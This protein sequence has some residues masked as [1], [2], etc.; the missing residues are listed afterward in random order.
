ML[1]NGMRNSLINK[2]GTKI[3]DNATEEY[4][5]GLKNI[6]KDFDEEIKLVRVEINNDI[7]LFLKLSIDK[8]PS[9]YSKKRKR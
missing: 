9:I 6:K 4:I 8:D 2:Y 5:S 3:P 1:S 7:E